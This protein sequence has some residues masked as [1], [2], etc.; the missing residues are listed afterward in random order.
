MLI[1]QKNNG[2]LTLEEYNT[3]TNLENYIPKRLT[4]QL[5]NNYLSFDGSQYFLTDKGRLASN[6]YY[7]FKSFYN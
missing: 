5:N 7:F 2:N 6:I 1:L 3:K 4:E